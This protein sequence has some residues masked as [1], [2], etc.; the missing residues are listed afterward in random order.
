MCVPDTVTS[1]SIATLLTKVKIQGQ[2]RSPSTSNWIKNNVPHY[3]EI[4]FQ[5][6]EGK[7][8]TF[9]KKINETGDHCVK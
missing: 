4:P 7:Y 6:K 8:I 5:H 1:V 3:K 2:L 9:W